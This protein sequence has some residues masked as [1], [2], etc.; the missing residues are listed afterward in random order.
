MLHSGPFVFLLAD[1]IGIFFCVNVEAGLPRGCFKQQNV[2]K[3]SP[4][5]FQI[6]Y[7]S[8]ERQLR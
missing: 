6:S 5:T 7:G 4:G 2:A 1:A 3:G 8:L